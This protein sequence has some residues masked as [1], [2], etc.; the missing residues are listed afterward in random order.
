MAT[1]QSGEPEAGERLEWTVWP[2]R[3][4]PVLSVVV[5]LIALGFCVAAVWSFGN[6]G[7]G[8]LGFVVLCLALQ[9]HYVPTHYRLDGREVTV[10]G[11]GAGRW[12]WSEVPYALD[13]GMAIAL[14][15]TPEPP[16][17]RRGKRQLVLLRP[18]GNHAEIVAYLRRHAQVI[19]KRSEQARALWP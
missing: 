4:R 13:F 14:S 6:P 1:D 11:V 15:P 8:L 17:D 2:A 9:A 12:S 7:Y 16:R 10:R 18:E 3:Q 5:G 19:D